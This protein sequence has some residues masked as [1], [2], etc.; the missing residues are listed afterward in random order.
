MNSVPYIHQAIYVMSFPCNTEILEQSSCHCT[1]YFNN[2]ESLK[3]RACMISMLAK[4]RAMPGKVRRPQE[5][6]V[7]FKDLHIALASPGNSV[8]ATSI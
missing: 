1:K 2:F 4:D 7:Y 5:E 6:V 8:S 3:V